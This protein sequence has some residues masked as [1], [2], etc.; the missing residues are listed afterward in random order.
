VR[1]VQFDDFAAPLYVTVVR[2]PIPAAGG[3]VVDVRATGICRSDWHGWQG[4]DPDITSL[5]HVP[6][7]EFAGV[8]AAIG[9]DVSTCEVGDRVTVPF[10]CACGTCPTCRSGNGQVCPDQWQPGFSG[11][12]S[13]AELVAI[14]FADVNVVRLPD[15]IAD[16]SAAALGCRFAT[17]YRA[18]THVARVRPGDVVAVFGCGGVGLSAVM[19]AAALGAE[20]I[21][22]DVQPA[23]LARAAA[24]GATHTIDTSHHDAVASIRDIVGEGTHVGIDALGSPATASASVSSLRPRGRHVQ[25]GLLPPAVTRGRESIPMHTVIARE[26][27]VLGSHGMSAAEY[28]EMLDR[29]SSGL[30]RPAELVARTIGLDDVPAAVDGMSRHDQAGV[31]VCRP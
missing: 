2:D 5:P 22:L 21:A 10:V 30:L 13:F 9:A 14:P 12:G 25:V 28:P 1:A 26:L 11:P 3:I 18:V 19:I 20:V 29:I 16:E 4:H 27:I 23:A 31:T 6:G 8:V 15:G 24:S 17:A 7:H